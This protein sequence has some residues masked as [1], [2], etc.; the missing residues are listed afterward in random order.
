MARVVSKE[1]SLLVLRQ[2]GTFWHDGAPATH[3]RLRRFL[4]RQIRKDAHGEHYLYNALEVEGRGLMEEHVYFEVEDTALFVTTVH[5]D[6]AAGELVV[7][8]NTE[9]ELRLD[10]ARVVEDDAGRVYAELAAGDLARFDRHA[11]T[12]LEPWLEA[13][14]GAY[15][16]R[17]GSRRVPVGR[18]ERRSAPRP[19][20]SA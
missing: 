11:V 14:D 16:L 13:G 10:P 17:V 9:A 2:D 5:A 15:W 18:L 4:H 8:L 20:A 1:E 3:D 12:Q 6:E 19:P 7:R